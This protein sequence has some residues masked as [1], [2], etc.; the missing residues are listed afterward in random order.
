MAGYG[1]SLH[2]WQGTGELWDFVSRSRCCSDKLLPCCAAHTNSFT[3]VTGSRSSSEIPQAQ[4]RTALPA[5]AAQSTEVELLGRIT[6]ANASCAAGGQQQV[7]L[8][9]DSFPS[10]FTLSSFSCLFQEWSVLQQVQQVRTARSM[11]PL[12]RSY[13]IQR[14]C[15]TLKCSSDE[16]GHLLTSSLAKCPA[17]CRMLGTRIRSQQLHSWLKSEQKPLFSHRFALSRHPSF[18]TF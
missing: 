12:A 18:T 7:S 8:L 11:A 9:V 6:S 13:L 3:H 17:C 10:N 16:S 14:C 2:T 15:H 5:V 4:L 1:T